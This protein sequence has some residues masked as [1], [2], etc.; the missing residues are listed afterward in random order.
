MS[1]FKAKMH[2]IISLPRPLAVFKGPASKRREGEE[3]GEGGRRKGEGRKDEGKVTGR[4]RKEGEGPPPPGRDPPQFFW[5][6]TPLGNFSF[7]VVT[8]ACCN[9]TV[10]HSFLC[11]L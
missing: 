2:K 7:Q 8:S 11:C 6:R 10:R 4:E 1:A 5:S 3:R 9:F